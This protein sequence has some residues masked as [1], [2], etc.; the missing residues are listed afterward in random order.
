MVESKRI[1][2]VE[3]GEAVIY[4]EE[5]GDVNLVPQHTFDE[6]KRS[7]RSYVFVAKFGR[8]K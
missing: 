8:K 4:V 1:G 2:H 6:V 3:D 7:G 5:S